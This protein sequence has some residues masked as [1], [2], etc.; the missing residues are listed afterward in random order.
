MRVCQQTRTMYPLA[1][2]SS[3]LTENCRR[4]TVRVRA[5]RPPQS[6]TGTIEPLKDVPTIPF[7]SSVLS[8]PL[9]PGFNEQ[10]LRSPLVFRK[11]SR[12]YH[13]HPVPLTCSALASDH[14]EG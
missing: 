8:G 13:A 10:L 11:G 1:A 5:C 7:L 9:R 14:K 6:L 2:T 12:T 3:R 4:L